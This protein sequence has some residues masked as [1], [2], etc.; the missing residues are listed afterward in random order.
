MGTPNASGATDTMSGASGS[1]TMGHSGSKSKKQM[2]KKGAVGS[3]ASSSEMKKPTRGEFR[4][5]AHHDAF[6]VFAASA[7]QIAVA[8][9]R[10]R[11]VVKE[12]NAP[13]PPKQAIVA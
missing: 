1:N 3:P 11:L 9:I 6:A 7:I 8:I 5:Y 4:Q 13:M 10:A 2:Q 12:S